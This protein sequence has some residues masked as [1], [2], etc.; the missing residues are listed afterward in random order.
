ML[1]IFFLLSYYLWNLHVQLS[2]YIAAVVSPRGHS[3][4]HAVCCFFRTAHILWDEP[5]WN[6]FPGVGTTCVY[7]SAELFFALPSWPE[8]PVQVGCVSLHSLIMLAWVSDFQYFLFSSPK[9]PAMTG[10]LV[11]SQTGGSNVSVPCFCESGEG[12]T[13]REWLLV[14]NWAH[15]FKK[16]SLAAIST[17]GPLIQTALGRILP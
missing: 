9:S 1:S 15:I 12:D 16:Q 10:F 4:P 14:A 8:A 5:H 2:P 6:E 13:Y 17:Q 3:F 11:T 7:F